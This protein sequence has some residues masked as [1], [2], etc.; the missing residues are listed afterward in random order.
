MLNA[1]KENHAFT[2]F[3]GV[4]MFLFIVPAYVGQCL[5]GRAGGQFRGDD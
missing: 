2:Y 5:P 4:Q 1:Q 3:Y